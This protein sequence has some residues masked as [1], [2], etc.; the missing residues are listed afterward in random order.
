[1]K[2]IYIIFCFFLFFAGCKTAKLDG[3]ERF[4]AFGSGGG[5]TGKVN[6]YRVSS[7]GKLYNDIAG[8]SSSE[9]K[10]H[11]TN[12]TLKNIFALA[13]S[14]QK[15]TAPFSNPGNI[16]YFISL[17]NNIERLADDHK[18]AKEIGACLAQCT[19]V[20]ELLPVHTNIIIFKL[21]DQVSSE[22]F[23]EKLKL[24]SIIA[25]TMG[26][27]CIRFVTH[28]DFNDEM[29]AKLIKTLNKISNLEL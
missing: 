14:L 10:T 19:F 13:D 24:E 1:M 6:V 16:Y 3:P 12:K 23:L 18:R 22:V 17:K 2:Y 28:L 4:I 20:Q 5:I 27:Q 9:V 11:L 8:S 15:S 25:N 26:K 21:K 7:F 29:L